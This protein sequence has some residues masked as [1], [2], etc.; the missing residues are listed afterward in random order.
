MKTKIKSHV[1][2]ITD[3]YDKKISKGDSNHACLA[4]IW[5]DFTLK[6]DGNYYSQVFLKECNTPRKK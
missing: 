2:E 5:L 1:N 6:K 3:F 4:L